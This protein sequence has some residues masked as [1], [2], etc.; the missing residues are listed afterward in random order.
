MVNK[1]YI[2]ATGCDFETSILC[3]DAKKN[4]SP[5]VTNKLEKKSIGSTSS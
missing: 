4:K 5:N 1:G 3:K 2:E